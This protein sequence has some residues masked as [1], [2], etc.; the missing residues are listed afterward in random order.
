M[1]SMQKINF[2]THTTFCDGKDTPE[3]MAQ[4]A[5]AKGFSVLGF[6]GHSMFPF[7]AKWHIA[8]REHQAYVS[9][10]RKI[11]ADYEGR[12]SI[13]CGFEADYVRGICIPDK[14]F[15]S[16]LSPDFLIGSVHYVVTEKGHYSV[17]SSAE[18]VSRGLEIL[19]RNDGKQAVQDYFEAQRFMLAHGNFEI[20]GHP[21]LI[22][23]RNGI[24][25]F[26]DENESWYR[27]EL[28]L[29]A[30]AA[31]AA[32]VIAEINTGA[33]ARGAMDALY[34]SDEF[35]KIIHDEGIPVMINSD[36]HSA[37]GLDCAFD[38]AKK[39]ALRAGYTETV[40][41]DGGKINTVRIV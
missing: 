41:P 5:F 32:G 20:W 15:Y 11:A 33:I 34:P 16:E 2:H 36:A 21:D 7:A 23:K 18:R 22:R 25:H 30:K 17:D 6:S 8:P 35:L 28:R 9:S 14:E 12:M 26:F 3:R 31:A 24:L 27:E 10:I 13:K 1:D 39:A 38:R 37:D 4:A 40:W 29:T 19:Y